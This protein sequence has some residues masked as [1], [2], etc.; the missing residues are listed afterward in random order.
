MGVVEIQKVT[1]DFSN[2]LQGASCKRTERNRWCDNSSE[3]VIKEPQR[4]SSH[5]STLFRIRHNLN[6]FPTIKY[7]LI[8][9]LH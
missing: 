3:S 6:D 7:L 8:D 1:V 2:T 9:T 4:I 5:Y